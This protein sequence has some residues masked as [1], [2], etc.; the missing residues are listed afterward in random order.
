MIQSLILKPLYAVD[1]AE[2]YDSRRLHH[3]NLNRAGNWAFLRQ[4]LRA[5]SPSESWRAGPTLC[6]KRE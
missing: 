5:E 1:D 2:E 3:S 6:E 4:P